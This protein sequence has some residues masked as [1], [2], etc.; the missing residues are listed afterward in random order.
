M[1]GGGYMEDYI[2]IFNNMFEDE[3]IGY[4]ILVKVEW[5]IGEKK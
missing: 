1:S 5:K 3:V 2:V 4:D